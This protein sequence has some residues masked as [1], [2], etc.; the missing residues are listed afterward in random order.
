MRGGSG[1]PVSVSFF[2][3]V[4]LRGVLG[5][6]KRGNSHLM[7]SSGRVIEGN[8]EGDFLLAIWTACA[9]GRW[10]LGEVKMM[11]FW[12]FGGVK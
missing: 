7:F 11:G 3:L 4:V 6:W 10:G 8:R 9:G 12:N 2:A 5:F 1:S